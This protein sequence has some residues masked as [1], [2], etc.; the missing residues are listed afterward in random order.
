MTGTPTRTGYAPVNGLSMYYEIYGVGQPLILLHGGFGQ[1]ATL[2]ALLSELAMTRQIIAVDLQGHGRTSD[3]DR[4]LRFE[5]MGDDIAALI[6][7][8]GFAQADIMGYSLGGSTGLRAA[9]QHPELVRKLVLVSIPFKREGWYPESLTGME[10]M[11][12]ASFDF[13]RNTPLYQEYIRVAPRPQDFPRLLDKMGELLRRPYDWSQ[14]VAALTLPT[15]LVYGDADSIPPA[16][17]AQFFELLGGGKRDGSWD[18]SGMSTAQL[19][20]LPGS[21]HYDII[22]SPLLAPAVTRFLDPSI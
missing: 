2:G 6:A 22:A 19:A 1:T 7:F 15:M 8:L 12:A 16:H 9:L 17:A 4:P 10:R 18:R 20:I 5:W 13:M 3:I 21:T 14:E 11:G